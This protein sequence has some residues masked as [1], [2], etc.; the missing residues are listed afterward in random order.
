MFLEA[1]YMAED[2]AMIEKVSMSVGKDL[3]TADQILDH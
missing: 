2:K 3:V 1:C